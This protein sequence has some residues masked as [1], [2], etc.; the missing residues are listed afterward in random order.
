[1]EMQ[2]QEFV[3][4]FLASIKHMDNFGG[5]LEAMN[6]ALMQLLV[7]LGLSKRLLCSVIQLQQYSH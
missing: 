7:E 5:E 1:M 3:A 2:E 4:N 6:I